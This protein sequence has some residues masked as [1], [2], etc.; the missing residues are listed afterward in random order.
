MAILTTTEQLEEVQAAIT[1]VMGSQSYRAGDISVQR[2]MLSELSKREE[3]LQ[4]RYNRE[5][6][7]S[8]RTRPDFSDG[9]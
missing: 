4:A 6:R 7:G 9:I 1:A 5:Q 8:P 3:M 2:A